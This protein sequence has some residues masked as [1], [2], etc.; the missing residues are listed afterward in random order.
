MTKDC[1]LLAID[2]CLVANWK[3]ARSFP[4]LGSRYPVMC[5]PLNTPQCWVLGY[6]ERHL[7]SFSSELPSKHYC[8]WMIKGRLYNSLHLAEPK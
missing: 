6:S 3:V 2:G 8:Y 4:R 7:K 5:S 1:S